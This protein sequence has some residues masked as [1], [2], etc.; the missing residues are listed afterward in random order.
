MVPDAGFTGEQCLGSARSSEAPMKSGERRSR[1]ESRSW[2]G[3][4]PAGS[5]GIWS[6]GKGR[7]TGDGVLG[8]DFIPGIKDW[9]SWNGKRDL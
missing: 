5:A 4:E 1:G 6:W 8:R 9:K 7:I 3:P 2:M